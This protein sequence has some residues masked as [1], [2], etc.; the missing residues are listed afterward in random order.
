MDILTA[1]A[2]KK[3]WVTAKAGRPDVNRAGNASTSTGSYFGCNI[4]M[5]RV[6]LVLRALAEGRIGW[7]FWPPGTSLEQIAS[8]AGS[9]GHGIW[10]PLGDSIEHDGTESESDV[11]EQQVNFETEEEM[12]EISESEYDED[13]SDPVGN[14]P[15]V[16]LGRFGAL[17]FSGDDADEELEEE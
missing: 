13:D 9:E 16:G 15:V 2:E 11:E 5:S 7:A 1:Y 17:S 10:I 3:G 4:L 8:L 12:I 14:V 6:S